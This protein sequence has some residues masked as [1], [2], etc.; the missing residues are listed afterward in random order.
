MRRNLRR[1]GA[2]AAAV[3]LAGAM[4]VTGG[5]TAAHA[6]TRC[7]VS[8]IYINDSPGGDPKQEAFGH[9][10][11]TGNHYVA[12]YVWLTNV[13]KWLWVWNADNDGGWDGDTPD[14]SYG[15]SECSNTP[16]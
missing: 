10:H 5:A 2:L 14:T 13:R 12:R 15:T 16:W 3:S 8:K 6:D 4:V 9:S 11:D 7:S 1:G